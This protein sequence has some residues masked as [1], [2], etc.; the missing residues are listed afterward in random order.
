[1]AMVLETLRLWREQDLFADNAGKIPGYLG[2]AKGVFKEQGTDVNRECLNMNEEAQYEFEALLCFLCSEAGHFLLKD[3]PAMQAFCTDHFQ[4]HITYSFNRECWGYRVMTDQRVWYIACTPWNQMRH[5]MI[6]GYDRAGLMA[7]L[8]GERGL[9]EACYGVLR[10]TGERI[11]VRF[12]AS[13]FESFPQ[14]GC[15][16]DENAEFAAGANKELKISKQQQAAMENGVIFG[17]DHPMAFPDRYDKDGYF[18]AEESKKK[19]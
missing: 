15:N 9:P 3:L 14:Y 8:A 18:M 2:M 7:A 13:I 1:M 4:S 16:A 10:Y 17:W 19:R 12:G 11:R 5:F 6:F